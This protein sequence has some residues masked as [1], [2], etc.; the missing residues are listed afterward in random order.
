MS[1]IRQSTNYN[2]DMYDPQPSFDR[3]PHIKTKE[4]LLN[5]PK[6]EL[7][8]L[9]SAKLSKYKSDMH[10]LVMQANKN[11]LKIKF[12]GLR[13]IREDKCCVWFS[14]HDIDPLVDF[15]QMA[16]AMMSSTKNN[17]DLLDISVSY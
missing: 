15:N 7:N 14:G 11:D 4:E 12:I 13:K 6:F 8:N 10:N 9:D 5:S 17:S 2:Q 1:I 16:R 3:G